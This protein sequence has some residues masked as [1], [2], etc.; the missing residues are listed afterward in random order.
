MKLYGV[1]SITC[2]REISSVHHHILYIIKLFEKEKRDF[3]F[4]FSTLLEVLKVYMVLY[5]F[6]FY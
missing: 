1:E 2:F 3:I 5:S 6:S 4:D